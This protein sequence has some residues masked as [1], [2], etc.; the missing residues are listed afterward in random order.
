MKKILSLI[1]MIGMV[2]M[3]FAGGAA[4]K[5]D[6][7]VLTFWTSTAEAVDWYTNVVTPAFKA[8][9][10]EVKDVE[11]S[12]TS[13]EDFNKKLPV[14]IPAG[15]AP[16][17]MEME[18]SWATQFITAGYISPN[19]DRL[20]AVVSKLKPSLQKAIELNGKKYGVPAMLIHEFMYY[21]KTIFDAAGIKEFPNTMDEML[22]VA[23]KLTKRDA[24]GA[25]D[26]SGFS[27]RLG[28]NPN[29]TFQKFWVLA[30]L[31][32]GVEMV[33]ESKTTPGKYHCAFDNEAG[34]NA[35][36]LYIDMLYGYKVDDFNSMKDSEAFAAGK[37]AINMRESQSIQT[38][39]ELGPNLNWG[40]APMP[41]GK[42]G[43]RATF[44]VAL[45]LYVP[46]STKEAN[47]PY[48]ESFIETALEQK[49]QE[50]MVRKAFCLSPLAE[51]E[52]SGLI[53]PRAEAGYFF[54]ED[55]DVYSVPI[56]NAYDAAAT[57]VG[58]ALPT[59]FAD[60]SLYNNPEG[61]RKQVSY[62]A[63]LVNEVYKEYGEYA[64]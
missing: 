2:T 39:L 3:L 8:K 59:I 54:P 40:S 27:M 22:E 24:S 29:G 52:Y 1:L 37:T 64:E 16:D 49:T 47:K 18:D 48:A 57:R 58:M 42:S 46:S 4:E 41:I 20:N 38:I 9:H 51:F 43:R 11:I 50:E 61:I 53:D 6:D 15:E 5:K 34:Y 44:E 45:N 60:A 12:F 19:S 10:P 23:K 31:S 62:L 63:S 25:V 13:I 35:I 26:V 7:I 21:N 32:N 33:E 55:M 28:G 36:K 14:V 56:H 30:L 17:L